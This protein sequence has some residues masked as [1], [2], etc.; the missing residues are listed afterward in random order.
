MITKNFTTG[1]IE[2]SSPYLEVQWRNKRIAAKPDG[3]VQFIS[4]QATRLP[5]K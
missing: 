3:K 2:P 4:W 5:T 1:E